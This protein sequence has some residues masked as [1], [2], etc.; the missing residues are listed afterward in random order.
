MEA[1]WTLFGF[2]GFIVN[3]WVRGSLFVNK[4]PLNLSR[5]LSVEIT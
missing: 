1:W 4:V 2:M 3:R 5:T